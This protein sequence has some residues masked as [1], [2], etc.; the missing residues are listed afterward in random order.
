MQTAMQDK[1]RYKREAKR[2]RVSITQGSKAVGLFTVDVSLGGF[3]VEA[4]MVLTPGTPVAGKVLGERGEIPFVGEI[5]WSRPG[6][7]S[8]NRRGKMGVRFHSVPP[9]MLKLL[10]SY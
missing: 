9:G 2:L 3:A 7:T 4:V 5:A 1:R 6:D 8:A 10:Q